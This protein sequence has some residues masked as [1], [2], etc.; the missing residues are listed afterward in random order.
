MLLFHERSAIIRRIR[1]GKDRTKVSGWVSPSWLEEGTTCMKYWSWVTALLGVHGKELAWVAFDCFLLC[2][3][4]LAELRWKP[5]M[6]TGSLT[7]FPCWS[8]T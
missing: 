7:A 5:K 8:V 2:S 6:E 1:L 3:G 4:T